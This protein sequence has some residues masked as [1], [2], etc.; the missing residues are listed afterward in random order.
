MICG[1]ST[2]AM[3]LSWQDWVVIVAFLALTTA[4]G[5]LFTS[6]AGQSIEEFFVSGRS[7]PWWLAGTSMV[8]TT[9]AADTPLAITEFVRKYGIYQNW[10]WWSLGFGAILST[11]LLARMWRRSGVRTDVQLIELRYDGPAAQVLRGFRAA[12]F[13][14]VWNLITMAWVTAAMVSIATESMWGG[15][16]TAVN[17]RPLFKIELIAGLLLLAGFYS[18]FSG[19][20]GVVVTDLLQFVLAMVGA[21]A[22]AVFAVRYVGGMD[23]LFAKLPES[24]FFRPDTTLHLVPPAATLSD[25]LLGAFGIFLVYVGLFWWTDKTVDQGGYLAQRLLSC[26]SENHA[27]GASLWFAIAHYALRPWPWIIAA[28]ATLVLFPAV[29]DHKATYTMLVMQVMGPWWRGLLV[30]SLLAAFISTINTQLNW[31]ASYLVTD[32]YQRYLVRNASAR[33]YVGVSRVTTGL[34]LIGA[35]VVSY[36]IESIEQ[37]WK[38][39]A[40][41]GAGSGLVLLGRWLWWRVNAWSELAALGTALAMSIV[42][43]I[44]FNELNFA[45]KLVRVVPVVTAAWLA[46]TFLA[47]PTPKE[48]LAEFVRRIRPPGPG[49]GPIHA[50]AGTQ[51][52]RGVLGRSAVAWLGGVGLVFGL[53]FAIGE[54]LLAGW[55]RA[56][57]WATAAVV[58]AAVFFMA[59]PRED[60]SAQTP[61]P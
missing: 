16:A 51:P 40:L 42:T 47:A 20:W 57:P 12:Y 7:L 36:K 21:V 43:A 25:G 9:F 56:I 45:Q 2:L 11:V 50:A 52:P 41:L 8:A 10:W 34:L 35:G 60:A 37:A 14:I 59:V 24:K 17:L 1:Q 27:L 32:L 54:F 39:L 23:V 3:L 29:A 22:L 28:L 38:F 5:L 19:L 13:G 33:H 53:L 6:R 49:W 55:Q 61:N 48:K 44:W 18:I 26:K 4:V 30:A 58:G 46:A 31:G 15:G